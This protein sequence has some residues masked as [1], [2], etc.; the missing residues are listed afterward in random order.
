MV[1]AAAL[2]SRC[3]FCAAAAAAAAALA[4]FSFLSSAFFAAAASSPSPPTSPPTSPSAS[5][6]GASSAASSAAAGAAAGSAGTTDQ[7][8]TTTADAPAHAA[9]PKDGRH[10]HPVL[11]SCIACIA[12]SARTELEPRPEPRGRSTLVRS[13]SPGPARRARVGKSSR[14]SGRPGAGKKCPAVLGKRLGRSRAHTSDAAR[15]RRAPPRSAR[16]TPGATRTGARDRKCLG[17]PHAPQLLPPTRRTDR[18]QAQPGPTGLAGSRDA[19][20]QFWARGGRRVVGPDRPVV[21]AVRCEHGDVKH[22]APALEGV[23]RR[24]RPTAREVESGGI[25]GSHR[26]HLLEPRHRRRGGRGR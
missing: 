8:G 9:S 24:I 17:S 22:D 7:G 5:S 14:L 4:S 11:N 18:V 3:F 2:S 12:A 6:A 1:C 20:A 23:R 16:R 25:L 10:S 15:R 13:S 26:R 19:V 21:A